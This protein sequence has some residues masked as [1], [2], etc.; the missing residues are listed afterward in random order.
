MKKMKN[1]G[2]KNMI[3]IKLIEIELIYYIEN[4]MECLGYL[5]IER[6]INRYWRYLFILIYN[7]L[8]IEFSSRSGFHELLSMKSTGRKMN[9]DYVQL[10]EIYDRSYG[11]PKK[12]FLSFK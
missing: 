4:G 6:A 3:L 2:L 1:N 7:A 12:P 5:L 8:R 11:E 10:V 9:K